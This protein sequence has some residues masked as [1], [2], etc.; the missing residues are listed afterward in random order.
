M[1]EELIRSIGMSNNEFGSA[2]IK[3]AQNRKQKEKLEKSVAV[4]QVILSSLDECEK[5]ISYF[6]G[7]K[8]T[9]ESQLEAIEKGEFSF[10]TYGAL[11]YNNPELNRK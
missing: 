4:V 10:D 1:S 6:Q 7:W 3:E 9:H 2:L 8:K 11:T 5:Q